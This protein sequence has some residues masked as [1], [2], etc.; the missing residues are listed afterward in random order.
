MQQ[1]ILTH[2]RS[3]ATDVLQRF[4]M[5]WHY[6]SIAGTLIAQND[7][8]AGPSDAL[9]GRACRP[10]RSTR[11]CCFEPSWAGFPHEI[12]VAQRLDTAFP[13]GRKLRHR[14]RRCS[15]AMPRI[16]TCR[17]GHGMNT[18]IGDAC[19]L[20]WKLAAML[21][22][23]GRPGLLTSYGPN[24]DRSA[25]ATARPR[26]ATAGCAPTSRRSIAAPAISARRRPDGDAARRD[27]AKKIAAL[28]NAENESFGIE[29]GYAYA[30]SP[31]DLQRAG[32][33]IPNDPLHYD[34]DHRARR[35]AAERRAAPRRTR[36]STGSGVVHAA[37]LRHTPERGAGRGRGAA[38]RT[39]RSS[40]A[41]RSN[42]SRSMVAGSCGA[43]G[44]AHRLA[45]HAR[46]TILAPRTVIMA[47]VLGFELA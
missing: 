27:A 29:L 15:P 6:Q 46:A 7:R 19:D 43:A 5:A 4:G 47:R 18:G 45:R 10:S 37:L 41:R 42:S 35:A 2:F 3:T 30:A 39:A 31:A 34:A 14:P 24:A 33:V 40:A 13:G 25:C 8:D 38:A 9:A 17:P 26:S 21:H 20:G 1:R 12:L 23:F 16:N 11:R 32:A 28:G 22:G 36:S 44:S